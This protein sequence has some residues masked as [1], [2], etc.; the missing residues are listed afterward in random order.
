MK[1]L[2]IALALIAVLLFTGLAYA[3]D[4]GCSTKPIVWQLKYYVNDTC[5]ATAHGRITSPSGDS[6]Q[7]YTASV[8]MVLRTWDGDKVIETMIVKNFATPEDAK[9]WLLTIKDSFL[10]PKVTK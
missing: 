7:P 6:T 10:Y 1:T 9:V 3:E 4:P 2:C 8:G 5:Y